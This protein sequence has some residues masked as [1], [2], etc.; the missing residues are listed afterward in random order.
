ML[1]GMTKNLKKERN[2][3]EKKSKL[4]QKRKHGSVSVEGDLVVVLTG[5][6]MEG[7]LRQRTEPAGWWGCDHI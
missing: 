3:K 1:C 2:R 6:K 5:K 7:E 4:E